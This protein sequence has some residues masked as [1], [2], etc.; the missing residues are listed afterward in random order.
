AVHANEAQRDAF[1]EKAIAAG[2][3]NIDF[4]YDVNSSKYF[5]Y[6]Q[7]FDNIEYASRVLNNK[8]NAPYNSKMSMVKIEN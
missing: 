8:D 1:L 2:Q 6:Y 5:I 3:T 4:F 7:K